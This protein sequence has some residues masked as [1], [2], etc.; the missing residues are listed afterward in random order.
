M[1]F[2]SLFGLCMWI[3]GFGCCFA[4]CG[5][6]A[7]GISLTVM[8]GLL[9]LIHWGAIAG[10]FLA[11]FEVSFRVESICCNGPVLLWLYP[12]Y[13]VCYVDVVVDIEPLWVLA[14]VL[15]VFEYLSGRIYYV[16]VPLGMYL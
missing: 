13:F 7:V 12:V 14:R 3:R 16:G 8:I 1:G 6:E 9:V 4:F 5:L 2:V 10:N 15:E 11:R